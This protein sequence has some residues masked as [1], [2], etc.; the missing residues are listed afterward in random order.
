MAE[1]DREVM[2][3]F[4]SDAH[5]FMVRLWRENRDDPSQTAEW[6][7]WIEHVQSGER[8]YFQEPQAVSQIISAFIGEPADFNGRL[9]LPATSSTE[10]K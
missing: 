8:R 3:Y 1:Q 6:R 2:T 9:N 5:S 7:G 10:G 4:E